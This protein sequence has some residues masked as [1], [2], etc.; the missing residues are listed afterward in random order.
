MTK[1]NVIA[2]LDAIDVIKFLAEYNPDGYA[3]YNYIAEENEE[4]EV[5]IE[6]DS[7]SLGID[8]LDK[9]IISTDRKFIRNFAC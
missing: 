1:E 2:V 7:I 5:N 3:P 4:I 9:S 8:I 6:N